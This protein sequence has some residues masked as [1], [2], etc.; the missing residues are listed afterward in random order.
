MDHLE[1]SVRASEQREDGLL[2]QASKK[3][4]EL[5]HFRDDVLPDAFQQILRLQVI[6]PSKLCEDAEYRRGLR[7]YLLRLE[8]L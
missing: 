2:I 1:R 3:R 4:V 5:D 7:P 8:L 6:D